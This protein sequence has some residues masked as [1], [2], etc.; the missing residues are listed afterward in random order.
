ML[1]DEVSSNVAAASPPIVGRTQRSWDDFYHVVEAVE[2]ILLDERL[3]L[4]RRLV[5]SVRFCNLLEQCKLKRV[6]P[7]RSSN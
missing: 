4:V 7:E 5:H 3:P 6:V 2:R 1:G